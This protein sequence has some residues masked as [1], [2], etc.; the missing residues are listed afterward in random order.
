MGDNRDQATG[1]LCGSCDADKQLNPQKTNLGVSSA[2]RSGAAT[3]AECSGEPAALTVRCR[4]YV[5]F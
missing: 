1:L 4:S 5:C 3:H 2:G